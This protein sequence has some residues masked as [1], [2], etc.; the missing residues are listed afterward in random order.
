MLI[1]TAMVKFAEWGIDGTAAFLNWFDKTFID[2]FV[3][4]VQKMGLFFGRV[5]HY[6]DKTM[7][8]GI[9][10]V[11]AEGST[12]SGNVLR[13]GQSGKVAD[14]AGLIV[15]GVVALVILIT[16]IIPHLGG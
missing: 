2:G 11:I 7:V 3:N 8:E 12:K 14:Y 4:G 1:N 10:A 15:I 16:F 13:K 5:Y 9:I 6:M